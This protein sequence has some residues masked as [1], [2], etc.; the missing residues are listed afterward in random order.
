MS[1]GSLTLVE[2][3]T[4]TLALVGGTGPYAPARGDVLSTSARSW[5]H[6]R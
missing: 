4:S 6:T 2:G 1:A 3:T 5:G